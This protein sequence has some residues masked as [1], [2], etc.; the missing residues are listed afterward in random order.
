MAF[1]WYASCVIAPYF[2]ML[3]I[4]TFSTFPLV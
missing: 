3:F 1:C 2:F 4:L